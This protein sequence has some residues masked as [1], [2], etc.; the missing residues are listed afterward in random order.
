MSCIFQINSQLQKFSIVFAKMTFGQSFLQNKLFPLYV[1]N[2]NT[3]RLV[4]T[5]RAGMKGNPLT[6][7]YLQLIFR[8]M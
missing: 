8:I 4:H 1:I 5:V 7:M 2:R 3:T 6:S